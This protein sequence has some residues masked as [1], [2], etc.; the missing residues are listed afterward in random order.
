MLARSKSL[1]DFPLCPP[2]VVNPEGVLLNAL[3]A[4]VAD[5]GGVVDG[6]VPH[7]F[8]PEAEPE[9]AAPKTEVDPK[10][11][12]GVVLG[13]LPNADAGVVEPNAEEPNAV[14]PNADF[15]V[16]EGVVDAPPKGE[17]P[18]PLAFGL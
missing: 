17:V 5:A 4:L 7:A 3:K 12:V 16:V 2:P 13:D 8:F 15:G 1:N 6:V 11:D 14:E 9:A 18:V 10:A